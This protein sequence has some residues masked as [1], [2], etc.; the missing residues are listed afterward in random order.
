MRAG[1]GED[2]DSGNAGDSGCGPSGSVDDGGD[3]AVE[4][5]GAIERPPLVRVLHN[6][7][8]TT[9]TAPTSENALSNVLPQRLSERTVGMLCV[10]AVVVFLA[11]KAAEPWVFL[12]TSQDLLA[13]R[14]CRELGRCVGHGAMTSVNP[15]VAG[16]IWIDTLSL[17]RS[18]GAGFSTIGLVIVALNAC[19]T[20]L[21]Y[22]SAYKVSRS[23]LA[24]L[25]AAVL[26]HVWSTMGREHP[27]L[28]APAI[29]PL[30]L[31]GWSAAVVGL[32]LDRRI[33]WALLGSISL[34]AAIDAHPVSAVLL[35]PWIVVL[36]AVS[37]R[38]L[39]SSVVSLASFVALPAL[40]SP[41]AVRIH[42][43]LALSHRTEVILFVSCAI[44]LGMVARRWCSPVWVKGHAIVVWSCVA[45]ASVLPV[46]MGLQ[47][48]GAPIETRYSLPA[49]A[50]CSLLF[51]L[52]LG[53]VARPFL[54]WTSLPPNGSLVAAGIFVLSHADKSLSRLSKPSLWTCANIE[55][56]AADP[57]F[58]ERG[59]LGFFRHLRG[60]GATDLVPMLSAL[61]H[62]TQ[63]GPSSDLLVVR[64]A[65]SIALQPPQGWSVIPL[66]AGAKAWFIERASILD[67]RQIQLC[68]TTSG[69]AKSKCETLDT[70][71]VESSNNGGF[72][73][74]AYPKIDGL[75]KLLRDVDADGPSG[76]HVTLE[77]PILVDEGGARRFIEI[78]DAE[79]RWSITNVQGIEFEGE[80]PAQRVLLKSAG[81]A[82]GRIV[83]ETN[84]LPGRS[85]QIRGR[86]APFLETEEHEGVIRYL[87]ELTPR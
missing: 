5:A 16:L 76:A 8:V 64:Q 7:T 55:A 3:R 46:L 50:P 68:I 40:V 53:K 41:G 1:R 24:S 84:I 47:L 83:M 26:F 72:G 23:A 21:V 20:L 86:L 44:A 9:P 63:S 15:L 74:M 61:S 67:N 43:N 82:Q 27:I 6:S 17:L 11:V 12:D 38:P 37:R 54:R 2:P 51:A 25:V 66:D 75:S 31:A 28:W 58:A 45:A 70:M 60:P 65:P 49:A 42:G 59:F 30:P 48:F 35:L 4:M 29:L 77:I 33:R 14:D 13:I 73:T 85:Y 62:A 71:R 69:P 22:G 19:A 57:R 32:M 39:V 18:L 52:I 56:L 36:F 10:A 34:S 81:A 80:L 78:C 79:T 87:N